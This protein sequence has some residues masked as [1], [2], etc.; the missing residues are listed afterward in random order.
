V[1][2]PRLLLVHD[3]VA[4][5][6]RATEK[7]D[8]LVSKDVGLGHLSPCAGHKPQS[9]EPGRLTTLRGSVRVT[10][11]LLDKDSARRENAK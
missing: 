9:R 7:D 1:V 6:V 11:N 5:G 4:G 3:L 8:L 2:E 10:I